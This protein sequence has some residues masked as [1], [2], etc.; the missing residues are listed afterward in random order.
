MGE[1]HAEE[2]QTVRVAAD[3]GDVMVDKD[4]VKGV[5]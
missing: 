1:E 4:E 3:E 5:N 2:D